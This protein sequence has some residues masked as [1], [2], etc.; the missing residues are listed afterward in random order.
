LIVVVVCAGDSFSWL[1][2]SRR[3]YPG[4]ATATAA[5]V[6]IALVQVGV[7]VKRYREY[8]SLP[9]LNLPGARLVHVEPDIRANFHWMVRNLKK[10]CDSF[11][12]LP[13]LYSLNF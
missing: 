6:L 10:Q 7:G 5:L 9:S 3:M 2:A 12:S 1:S 4:R 11:E 8:R 13:G